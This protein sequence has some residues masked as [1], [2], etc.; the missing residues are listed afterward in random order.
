MSRD[1][2]YWSGVDGATGAYLRPPRRPSVLAARARREPRYGFAR[3]PS[4]AAPRPVKGLPEGVDP[5]DLS[6]AGWGVVFAKGADPATAEA[7]HEL[8]DWRRQ[9]SGEH[10]RELGGANGYRSGESTLDFIERL[11][12][13][14]GPAQPAKLPYYLLLVG[15][16]EEIPFELQVQLDVQYAVG[17]LDFDRP[18]DY[19]A[20]ARRVVEY[21][22]ACPTADRPRAAIFAPRIPGDGTTDA[23]VEELAAPLAKALEQRQPEWLFERCLG[24]LATREA[25]GAWLGGD[26]SPALVFAACHGVGYSCGAERQRSL[27]GALVCSGWPGPGRSVGPEAIFT[28]DDL[29]GE[30]RGAPPLV[31]LFACH[32]L[33]TPRDNAFELDEDGR[34]LPFAPQS[35]SSRLAQRLLT[36]GSLA[37]VGHLERA[38]TWSFRWREAGRQLAVFENAVL[39]LLNG[40]PVGW[41]MEYFN[42]RYGELSTLLDDELRHA[43]AGN[44]RQIAQLWTARNDA[45]N[46]AVLGDP[47]V[48]LRGDGA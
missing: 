33:G 32:S 11:G 48:H 5:N 29:G 37:V 23:L 28:A 4:D 24:E 46:Y 8:L 14:P 31:F 38:W 15:S 13:G 30:G 18:D 19:A 41:A 1:L 2:L 47:A 45:R 9:R 22:K 21:E 10:Y 3:A 42:Q 7:L 20:Y 27:Q 17:R 25:L 16:P 43:R 34:P 6:G 40:L 26:R 44:D 35:F 39:R 12:V 36:R